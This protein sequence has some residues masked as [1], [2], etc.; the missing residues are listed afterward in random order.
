MLRRVVKLAAAVTAVVVVAVAGPVVWSLVRSPG[1]D[2]SL[3]LE[4]GRLVG[5]VAGYVVAVDLESHAVTVSTNRFGWRAFPLAISD[6]TTIVV[7]DKLGG[8]GDLW[9]DTPVRVSYEVLNGVRVAKSIDVAG[10]GPV[11]APAPTPAAMTAPAP[12]PSIGV[13]VVDP[14]P[15][16]STTSPAPDPRENSS[17]VTVAPASADASSRPQRPSA[18]RAANVIK[19]IPTRPPHAERPSESSAR[20][21]RPARATVRSDST[22]TDRLPAAGQAAAGGSADDGSAAIDWLFREGRR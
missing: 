20:S 8:L 2:S 18:G 4:D 5:D 16:A 12:L 9:K 1:P 14:T 11:P 22:A 17:A 13:T 3:R 15:A 7:Q 6:E 19:D 21:V 10:A